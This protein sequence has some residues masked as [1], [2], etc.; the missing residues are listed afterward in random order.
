MDLAETD[1]NPT[2]RSLRITAPMVTDIP[3]SV[4]VLPV[5]ESEVVS[6]LHI[7]SQ[8][9]DEVPRSKTP[10]WSGNP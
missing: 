6:R 7:G 8:E 9:N 2:E 3:Y 4:P 1:L 5:I 10:H